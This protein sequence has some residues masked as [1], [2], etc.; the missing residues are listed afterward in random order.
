M[1]Q[2]RQNP[3]SGTECGVLRFDLFELFFSYRDVKYLQVGNALFDGDSPFAG[4]IQ[5]KLIIKLFQYYSNKENA[6]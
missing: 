4:L 2:K 1:P 3:A 6:I 5:F